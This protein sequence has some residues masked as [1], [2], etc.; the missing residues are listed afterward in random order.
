MRFW[1]NLLG[2][3]AVWFC[4]VIAAAHGLLWPGL[5]SM[6][7]FAFWQLYLSHHPGIELRLMA[8]ALVCG[9]LIDGGLAWFGLANYALPELAAPPGG[10]PLWILALWLSFALTLTQSLRYLQ[11]YLWLA[12]LF[13]AIGGPL[14][15]LGAARVW[16]VVQFPVPQWHALLG[17]ALGWGL[18]MPLL[19]GLARRWS[20]PRPV[21]SVSTRSE[22]A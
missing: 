20:A 7:L 11:K 14:A 9:L 10:A 4:A 21:N 5:L 18:A 22:I 8:V 13:G 6:A 1:G 17:L 16:A 3:Q 2:Y 19:A 12:A 15:Y